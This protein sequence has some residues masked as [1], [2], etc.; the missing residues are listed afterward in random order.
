MPDVVVIGAGA[1]GAACA[2]Y[3]ARAG[4]DTLVVD[5]G[6]VA[7]GTTGAGEGN[8]L[9]S[10]KAPGPELALALLSRDLW[11]GL[12]AEGGDGGFE[13][14]PK[15]G[16]VVARTSRELT[17]LTALATAQAGQGAEHVVVPPDA[18]GDHE[19]H[20]AD[21]MAGGVLYPQDA[22][23]QP[24]LAAA[25]LIR[26]GAER[27]GGGT[28]ML[29]TGVTVTGLLRAGSRVTGVA[30]DHGDILAGA[31]VNAAG[32]WSGEIAAMAG[33]GLPILPRRGFVLVTEPIP[34]PLIRHKVYT[35]AY[36]TDVASDSENLETSAVVEATPSGPVLVG[37]S[38]ERVGFDRTTS[39]P[40]LERLARQAV[41]LF[42]V[43]AG[44]RA[45]RAYCGFR[46]YSPDHLPVIGEDPAAP[47]LH[48]ACGHEGAGIGLAPATGH[49]LAQTLAGVTPDLDLSPFRPGRFEEARR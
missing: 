24:A 3:A 9:V 49:L 31:V 4:L 43:L 29:R 42:P 23:V 14:E 39:I 48:H 21:G 16:L 7:A 30:T 20:L 8:V 27:F 32:T 28:L 25:G 45:I 15:G 6:S 35:A 37:A 13:Y 36:V 38:R 2:Y 22:Q 19:P 11:L 12:A 5:R 34:E 18:L 26:R 44:R 17:A 33:T 41:E 1:V 10:D 40:V 47:G 46:P